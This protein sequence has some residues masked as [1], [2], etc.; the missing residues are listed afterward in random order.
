MTIRIEDLKT[1]DFAEVVDSAGETVAP[2]QPGDILRHEFMDPLALSANALARDL[3]VPT[4]RVTAI[5]SGHRRISA[6][7]ALRLARHFGTTPEL[8]LNLQD[9][10]DLAV[11]RQRHGD[12]IDRTVRRRIAS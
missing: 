7:T 10:H 3:G 8:W 12:E 2:T 4:N 11:A 1:T 9:G 5:L 6:D